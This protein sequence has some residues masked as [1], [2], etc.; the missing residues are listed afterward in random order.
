MTT[1]QH[2]RQAG[3][4]LVLFAIA[5]P[6]LLGLLALAV[7]CGG[8]YLARMR[9]TKVARSSSATA[10]NMMAIR[11]WG[12]LVTD[13]EESSSGLDLGL[14]TYNAE[15]NPPNATTANQALLQEVQRAT[16]ESLSAYYPGDFEG[17]ASDQGPE[18]LRFKIPGSTETTSSVTLS[19]LD[20]TDSSV[21]LVVR[22][23]IPTYL[24]GAVSQALGMS[25][26]CQKMGSE[27]TSR[28]WV[29][30]SVPPDGKSGK[31]RRANVMM[32][33]D[34]S[35][36]M[37]EQANGKTKATALFEA[38]A[39][40]ID[41]FNPRNDRFA[42]I[43][44][45]TTADTGTTPTLDPLDSATGGG[46]PDYLP[47]K[48]AI[49]ALAV[50]GQTNQCDALIQVI[51]TLTENPEL[52]D[53]N[54]P[55]FVL[56]FTDGSPNVY[57]LNFCESDAGGDSSC[58]ATPDRLRSALNLP[59]DDSGWYG[60]TV[61]WDK[62]EVFPLTYPSPATCPAN[63][64][65]EVS[66]NGNDIPVCDP[67][68]AFPKIVNTETAQDLPYEEV[69]DHLRLR[70]DGEFVFKGGTY[71]AEGVTLA[72]LGYSLKFKDWMGWDLFR[73]DYQYPDAFKWHGPSYL[74]HS[75][76]RIPRGVSLIDRI[77]LS[78]ESGT[79]PAVTCGPGSRAPY[80]G[81]LTQFSPIVADKYNHS[82]YFAS[83]VVDR[84]WRYSGSPND[85]SQDKQDKTGLKQDQLLSAPAYFDKPH[86]LLGSP[87]DTPGCLTTLSAKIPFTD[88][89]IHVG[90]NFVSNQKSSIPSVGE[91]VKTA[92]LP[93][94][95]ALRAADYL[96]TQ[97]GV[98]IFVVGL[99]DN[100]S[101]IY[102]DSC[103]DPLQNPLDPNSRKDRFLRRLAFAPESLEDP[104]SFF[105]KEPME[106]DPDAAWGALYDFRF[107]TV[108][109]FGSCTNHPLAS[110][111]GGIET[112]Y[113]EDPDN[114]SGFTPGDHGFSPSHLGAYYAANNP[115]ELK[116]IFG[117]IAKRVLLRLAT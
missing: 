102:G 112:G 100:A 17:L 33:L 45:A 69:R 30:S 95:C 34:V 84:D 24:L 20:L 4:I 67:V 2:H 7:D 75:S 13:P 60:W 101:T 15:I 92:E 42:I 89:Q 3:V 38:A 71:G 90:N 70:E 5:L 48:T 108:D 111:T 61:K 114:I 64:S 56:L 25:T 63:G 46:I 109:S 76:F 62:R 117:E 55:K 18:Y 83:R 91:A 94:Y 50:G 103:K 31:M 73:R 40:F 65:G 6:V 14:K 80:P 66:G 54:V 96:R 1:N 86:T 10:L 79:T 57:R 59:G 77:P 26:I 53:R 113:Y 23:A 11:G 16:M 93:Y 99:G 9:L 49:S 68:W 116:M 97:Y 98:V 22:Y 36:S 106:I 72:E 88:A 29:E 21:R 107:R 32:L 52:A 43:P 12:S 74:V 27:Q 104:V 58:T 19:S 105:G 35:G 82:R 51:R 28:C 41:M 81:A 44:Y 110:A 39:N 37:N 115:R 85:D 78:L 87:N 47:V 8:L